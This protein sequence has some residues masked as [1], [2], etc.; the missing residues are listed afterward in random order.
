MNHPE[1]KPQPNSFVFSK[2]FRFLEEW[3]ISFENIVQWN[4]IVLAMFLL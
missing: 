4:V 1:I 3:F 2:S